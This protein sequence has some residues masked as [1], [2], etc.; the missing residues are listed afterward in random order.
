MNLPKINDEQPVKEL[1]EHE[2]RELEKQQKE[3][4][5]RRVE[6]EKKEKEQ[7]KKIIKYFIITA[8]I[9]VILYSFYYKYQNSEG[10][11]TPGMVHWHTTLDMSI[12]G[13]KV[14]LPRIGAG[15]HH[16]GLPLLHTHDDNII[17][18]EGQIFRKE[19]AALGK[20]MD[21]VGVQFSETEFF[22]MK[23]GMN[24]EEKEGTLK[25]F[26]NDKPSTLFRNYLAKNGDVVKLVFD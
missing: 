10:P 16:R 19:D 12:C 18:I 23:N 9:A 6:E 15:Q 14:D 17:H 8:V 7:N 3:E 26:I 11:Y 2:K 4:E 24:C 20:F 22:D 1:S 13:K 25:M 5:R 21:A